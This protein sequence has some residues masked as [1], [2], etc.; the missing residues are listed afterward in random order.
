M[1]EFLSPFPKGL[2]SPLSPGVAELWRWHGSIFVK[3]AV[4]FCFRFFT[5]L[6][7][8]PGAMNC[9][10]GRSSHQRRLILLRCVSSSDLATRLIDLTT[11]RVAALPLSRLEGPLDG[12]LTTTRVRQNRAAL[13]QLINSLQ[14]WKSLLRFSGPCPERG[15]R[16]SA[17]DAKREPARQRWD[18]VTTVAVIL[19][20]RLPP[21]HFL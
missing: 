16:A 9:W 19:L 12:L 8:R 21:L 5:A 3:R 1:A 18:S 14:N 6:S 2:K 15:L 7:F 10:V 17:A 13:C 4:K 20:Q 11:V